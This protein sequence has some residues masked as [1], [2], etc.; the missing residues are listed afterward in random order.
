MKACNTDVTKETV[1]EKSF[2]TLVGAFVYDLASPT[3]MVREVAQKC[4]TVLSETTNVGIAT[5]ID[6]CKHLLLAP[7]FV[8]HYEHYLS[9][10]KLGI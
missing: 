7:I 3:P 1:T 6:P 9:P 5:M 10:C 8:N 2:Q 4:L